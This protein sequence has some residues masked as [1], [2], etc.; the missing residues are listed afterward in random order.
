MKR[1]EGSVRQLPL[2]RFS[3]DLTIGPQEQER[4]DSFVFAWNSASTSLAAELF[5]VEVR[6]T[7]TG[8]KSPVVWRYPIQRELQGAAGSVDF[9][10]IIPVSVWKNA[11]LKPTTISLRV[12]PQGVVSRSQVATTASIGTSCFTP[13]SALPLPFLPSPS[14]CLRSA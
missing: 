12:R 14:S 9:R 6:L 7:P 11:A 13:H 2:S 5:A 1:F 8:A 10:D 4:P 3:P